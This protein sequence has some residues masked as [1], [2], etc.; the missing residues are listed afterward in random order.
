QTGLLKQPVAAEIVAQMTPYNPDTKA[1]SDVTDIGFDDQGRL[2]VVS[3]KPAAIHRFTPDPSSVYDGSLET[4]EPWLPLAQILGRATKS[5]NVLAHD[6][7]LYI[8]SGD[9]Y[10]YADGGDGTVYRVKLD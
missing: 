6:G 10:G 8:T 9:G 3:A 5:E 4:G 2:Y 1:T 7:Y